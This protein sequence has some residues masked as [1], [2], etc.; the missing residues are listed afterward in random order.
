MN[1]LIRDIDTIYTMACV[2]NQQ[3]DVAALMLG[4]FYLHNDVNEVGSDWRK[5]SIYERTEQ[6]NE[7]VDFVRANL[8]DLAHA[9]QNGG[10]EALK[11]VVADI[12]K[13]EK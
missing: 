6:Y 8:A 4:N 13:E 11:K 7:F 1:I 9:W 10:G 5:L 12:M 2:F 3:W